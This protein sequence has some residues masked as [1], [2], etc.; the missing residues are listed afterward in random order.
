MPSIT[1]R[2]LV[3]VPCT[4]F[5]LSLLS[6]YRRQHHERIFIPSIPHREPTFFDGS[7]DYNRD[8]DNLLFNQGQ[9]DQAFP[10]LFTEI[11]RASADRKRPITLKELDSITPRNGHVRAMIYDQQVS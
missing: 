4:F 9:C 1:R 5:V 7:W 11:E 3:L 6:H 10:G 2:L 8:K